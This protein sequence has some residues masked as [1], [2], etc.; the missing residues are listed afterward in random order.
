M[1]EA[2]DAWMRG[3]D[4]MWGKHNMKNGYKTAIGGGKGRKEADGGRVGTA[5]I[6]RER[7]RH[8]LDRF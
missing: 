6:G 8:D 5:D 3:D 4:I 7:Q 1:S 2:S